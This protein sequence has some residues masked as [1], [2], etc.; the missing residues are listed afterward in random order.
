MTASESKKRRASFAYKSYSF[1]DKD[2]IIDRIRTI[3]ADEGESYKEIQLRSSVSASTLYN[4]FEGDTKRPQFA[5]IMAVA[6]SLGYDMTLAK[7]KGSI[8]PSK[9]ATVVLLRN[10]R[11][12]A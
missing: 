12:V 1:V 9:K 3:V 4:W 11:K 2:P 7:M 10:G 8:A 5:T 6:R